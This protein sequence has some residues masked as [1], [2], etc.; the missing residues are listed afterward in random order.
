M[1]LFPFSLVYG[2]IT[3]FRNKLFDWGILPAKSFPF[4]VISVG[5]LSV[6]GTGK[7]PHV[8]YLIRLLQ[9]NYSV[10]TLSR[11]YKRKTKGFVLADENTTVAELGDEPLQFC[12]KFENI[13]VAV[14]EKRKRGIS[15]L[16]IQFPETEVVLLDDAFQ[17]RYVK[18][19][20]S[21]LLTDF[22]RLYINDYPLPTGNLREFRNGAKRADIIIVTKTSKVLSPITRQRLFEEIKPLP[23]QKLYFSYIDHGKF[24]PLPGIDF[25]PEKKKKYYSI[26]LVA[27]IAN[28]YPLEF[29][30]RKVCE[31]LEILTFPD[32]H[33]YTSKDIIHIIETFDNIVSRNKIIVTTEKD[34]MRFAQNGIINKLVRY[35]MCYVPIEI[36]FHGNDKRI[37]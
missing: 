36:K 32:H 23:R 34:S 30:L 27:G 21:I 19:G 33:Q 2:L 22:H 26:L 29:Y 9:N 13:K 16:K 10:A 35:P 12:S 24:T 7:S 14:D 17:H 15:K 3:F 6:G 25:V 28:T 37:R 20:L 11:G 31:E 4:P 8:E 18:P 1:I 5:N